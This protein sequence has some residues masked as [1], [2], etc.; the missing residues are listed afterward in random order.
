MRR[1]LE[2]D[3]S[4]G[5]SEYIHTGDGP[6]F[7]IESVA[8][9]EPALDANK[10]AYTGDVPK[11]RLFYMDRDMRWVAHIP[12]IVQLIWRSRYGVECW[13]RE[14]WPAVRRLLNDPDW[15]YLRTAPGKI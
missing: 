7:A 3:L 10:R 14:H 11:T 15:I 8:D 5:I 6:G 12:D 1:L 4:T 2:H 13:K 9:V